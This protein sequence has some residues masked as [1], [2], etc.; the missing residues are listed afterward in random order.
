MS[1]FMHFTRCTQPTP[2]RAYRHY[3]TSYIHYKVQDSLTQKFTGC[4]TTLSLSPT[5]YKLNPSGWNATV[6]VTTG[7]Y[8]ELHTFYY[9]YR[10]INIGIPYLRLR[11]SPL[12]SRY[13]TSLW[14]SGNETI[15]C[16]NPNTDWGGVLR[17]DNLTLELSTCSK[18]EDNF[19]YTL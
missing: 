12:W 16:F 2:S 15:M 7:L 17:Y 18:G 1:L 5:G 19:V 9:T 13:M 4:Y 14:D 10:C 8:A 11:I 3:T 6:S